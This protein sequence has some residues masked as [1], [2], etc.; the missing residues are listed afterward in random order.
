MTEEA[1]IVV[2]LLCCLL[3]SQRITVRCWDMTGQEP[4]FTA[5]REITN[6]ELPKGTVIEIELFT[7]RVGE[8]CQWATCVS[9]KSSIL[10]GSCPAMPEL[11]LHY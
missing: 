8:V 9:Q 5:N 2:T 7:E 10:T 6:L 11:C 3:P 4:S 1:R